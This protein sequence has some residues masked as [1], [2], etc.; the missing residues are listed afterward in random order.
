M[1]VTDKETSSWKKYRKVVKTLQASLCQGQESDNS[2]KIT[3]IQG[4]SISAAE[5][6]LQLW[7]DADI[8]SQEQRDRGK[9]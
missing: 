2:M 7:R 9:E 4:Q 6:V 5:D 1:Q 3:I 8:V